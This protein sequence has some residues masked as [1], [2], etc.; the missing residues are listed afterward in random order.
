MHMG[1]GV[2]RRLAVEAS[3]EDR[4]QALERAREHNQ[5]DPDW[6]EF[7]SQVTTGEVLPVRFHVFI[8]ATDTD[9]HDFTVDRVNENVWVGAPTHLPE[10]AEEVR[11][12]ASKD[13]G[14]LSAELRE[15]DVDVT[16]DQLAD[17]YVE[18]TLEDDLSE[19]AMS[20]SGGA[21]ASR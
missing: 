5:S 16:A 8:D 12:T 1:Q 21:T 10:L 4:D 15:R 14:P 7:V 20:L 18:V 3:L 2:V 11:V 9:G 6:H 19:A 17:M 13:F